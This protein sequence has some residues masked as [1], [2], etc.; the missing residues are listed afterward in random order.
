MVKGT[1][2][3]NVERSQAV[4]YIRVAENFFNG[5]EVAGEY[6]YWNASGVLIVHSAIAYADALTIK[7]GGVKS[8]GENHQEVIN[9]I[10]TLLPAGSDKK[11]GLLQLSKIIAH[12]NAVSYS[13]DI[14][15]KK[16]IDQLWKLLNRFRRWAEKLLA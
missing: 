3:V 1:Q 15:E 11:S 2:R 13:G 16:D 14:Y 4:N 6:E 5:A 10:D 7:Y 12:K 9:L 8:K